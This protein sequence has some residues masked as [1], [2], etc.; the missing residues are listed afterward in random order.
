[1]EER[2]VIFEQENESLDG[3]VMESAYDINFRSDEP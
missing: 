1:V 3:I 2:R